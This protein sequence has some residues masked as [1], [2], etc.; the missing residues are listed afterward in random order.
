MIRLRYKPEHCL[1]EAKTKL[2]GGCCKMQ[3]ILQHP[4]LNQSSD[5]FIKIQSL[6][7]PSEPRSPPGSLLFQSS[8][9]GGGKQLPPPLFVFYREIT[10]S[11]FR[12]FLP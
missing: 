8:N 7:P 3:S 2:K 5:K 4:P 6:M 10:F 11:F 1:R 12:P 9:N